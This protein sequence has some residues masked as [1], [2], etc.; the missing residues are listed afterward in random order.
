MDPGTTWGTILTAIG[1]AKSRSEARRNGHDGPIAAGFDMRTVGKKNRRSCASL[2]IVDQSQ[3][4]EQDSD[5]KAM[6]ETQSRIMEQA[7]EDLQLGDYVRFTDQPYGWGTVTA[8]FDDEIEVTR[9]FLHISDFT[10]AASRRSG[11]TGSRVL[12]Y[13]GLET[14]TLSRSSSR[15]VTV[16]WRDRVPD[17]RL[18]LKA[19]LA[20][21]ESEVP[22]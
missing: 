16:L 4:S 10:A 2:W 5:W 18:G 8:I 14:V 21:L 22:E 3:D 13:T 17:E 6:E 20:M 11:T 15:P 9:P 12:S 7:I 1:G 19:R